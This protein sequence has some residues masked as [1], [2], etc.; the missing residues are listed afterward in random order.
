MSWAS[1]HIAKLQKGETVQFRP[2]GNS[3]RPIVKHRQLVTVEPLSEDVQVGDV[4][5]CKISGRDYLH[6]VKG[7]RRNGKQILIGN[8]RGRV[9]GWIRKEAVFG[10]MQ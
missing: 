2:S 5:L 10:K 7:I 9:N 8:N 1:Y 4:V 3:M 6:L